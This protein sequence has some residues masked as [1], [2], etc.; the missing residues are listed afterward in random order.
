MICYTLRDIW[1][2][3]HKRILRMKSSYHKN[4]WGQRIH[5]MAA[6]FT[7]LTKRKRQ[8]NDVKLAR[9]AEWRQWQMHVH[10]R[11]RKSKQNN[12]TIPKKR[13]SSYFICQDNEALK[14]P[15]LTQFSGIHKKNNL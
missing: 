1:W 11:N 15:H 4:K 8:R 14:H 7:P 12:N 9:I 3:K 6:N 5:N 13:K 2:H 10:N